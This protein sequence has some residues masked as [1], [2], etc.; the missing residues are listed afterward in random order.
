MLKQET[1][2][3]LY[4]L[5]DLMDL[6]GN[7]DFLEIDINKANQIRK[8]VLDVIGNNTEMNILDS[9]SQDLLGILPSILLDSQK[10]AS[11]KEIWDFAEKCLNIKLKPYWAKRSRAE[12]VGIIINEVYHQSP[13]QF[14]KF[15]R[16]WN[17]FNSNG[18]SSKKQL[19][20]DEGG[21]GFIEAWFQF[22]D[23]YKGND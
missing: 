8:E 10:F 2:N 16:T 19:T 21:K 17:K 9:T 3:A 15:L 1:K 11:V 13:E 6:L 4:S 18:N 5:L 20:Y 7:I 14:N 23:K 22:F 12:T